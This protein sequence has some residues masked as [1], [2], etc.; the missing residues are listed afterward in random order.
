MAFAKNKA[1]LASTKPGEESKASVADDNHFAPV[2][3]CIEHR[4]SNAVVAGGSPAGSTTLN[5]GFLIADCGLKTAFERG[6]WF[7]NPR[8]SKASVP[9]DLAAL[10][11]PAEASRSEREG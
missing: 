10:A 4:A 3:Q 11:Q 8:L 5:C 7:C 1:A 2:A 6:R 9:I